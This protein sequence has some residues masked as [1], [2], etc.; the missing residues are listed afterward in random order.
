MQ[1]S[2]QDF[3]LDKVDDLKAQDSVVLDVR[4][5]SPITETMII[6]TG[7][8]KRHVH[9][10]ANHLTT[11]VKKAGYLVLGSEGEQESD[12]IVV[13]LD[14]VIVHIMQEEARALYELEKLW[15]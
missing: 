5:K 6:C 9:S 1:Q 14:E 2:I 4:G 12:W 3:I 7:T 15:S 8:S 13:D 11:E 10:I